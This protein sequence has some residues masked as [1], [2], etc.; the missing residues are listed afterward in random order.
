[1]LNAV[2]RD[3]PC[4][5]GTRMVSISF[6]VSHLIDR[7]DSTAEL[8]REREYSIQD[9]SIEFKASARFHSQSSHSSM[10]IASDTG[11]ELHRIFICSTL[12]CTSKR[13]NLSTYK[14]RIRRCNQSN[15][16]QGRTVDHGSYLSMFSH[17][18]W[19]RGVTVK[20]ACCN[21]E[22]E[23]GRVQ[24]HRMSPSFW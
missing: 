3:R 2:L 13:E 15:C 23:P 24:P 14:R 22:S 1:M 9:K 17:T 7:K 11:R 16:T 18:V 12:I 21:L 6:V 19:Q 20:T 5:S 10:L 4:Q 8:N